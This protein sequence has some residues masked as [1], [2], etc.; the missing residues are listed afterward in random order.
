[1]QCSPPPVMCVEAPARMF[2]LTGPI[3]Q[4]TRA[5]SRMAAKSIMDMTQEKF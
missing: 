4:S 1:M 3:A 5:V 2:C